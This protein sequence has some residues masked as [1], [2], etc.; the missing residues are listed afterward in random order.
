MEKKDSGDGLKSM[1]NG[2]III[3]NDLAARGILIV[4][5]RK[6]KEIALSEAQTIW[7]IE[8]LTRLTQEWKSQLSFGL[9]VNT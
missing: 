7:V 6:V 3:E 8:N 5:P 2:A 9:N 4:F 1:M